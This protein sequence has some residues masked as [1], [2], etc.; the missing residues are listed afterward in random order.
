MG[1]IVVFVIPAVEESG[2]IETV[3]LLKAVHIFLI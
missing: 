3:I 2:Y 1:E